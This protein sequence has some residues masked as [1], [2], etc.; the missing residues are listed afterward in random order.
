MSRFL[1]LA[2]V[3]TTLAAKGDGG[4]SPD[5]GVACPASSHAVTVQCMYGG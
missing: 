5:G 1:A 2:L 3:A 4:A